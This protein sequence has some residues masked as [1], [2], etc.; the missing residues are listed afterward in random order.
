MAKWRLEL[1][2]VAKL[3]RSADRVRK[4]EKAITLSELAE[5]TG[6][7]L[8]TVSQYLDNKIASP[9]LEKVSRLAAVLGLQTKDLIE[10]DDTG[11]HT[12]PRKSR[13]AEVDTAPVLGG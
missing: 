4:G 12:A 7:P 10:V 1:L 11:N 5:M 13:R 9:D 2:K 8:S 3:E 6:I